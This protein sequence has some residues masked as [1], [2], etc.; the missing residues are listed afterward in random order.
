M[1]AIKQ[2]KKKETLGKK[3]FLADDVG[4]Y[5]KLIYKSGIAPFDELLKNKSQDDIK[6]KTH[7]VKYP[8]GIE[9]KLAK[10]FT[11]YTHAISNE[12]IESLTFQNPNQPVLLIRCAEKK[13]IAFD[14]SM[15][16]LFEIL[17]LLR[18]SYKSRIDFG[19]DNKELDAF[20]KKYDF[21]VEQKDTPFSGRITGG[22]LF[23]LYV[24]VGVFQ[25]ILWLL[26]KDLGFVTAISIILFFFLLLPAY[27]QRLHDIN[28][29]G[30]Y[31]LYLLI[32]V[33]NIG[34]LVY[35]FITEGTKGDNKYGKDPKMKT[36]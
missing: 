3:M 23:L 21:I 26:S 4:I 19:I 9:V 34:Y 32:P 31:A 25:L 35:L 22:N 2:E 16:D 8:K 17:S 12:N 15:D 14:F 33:F 10:L 24:S 18:K 29:S 1:E 11:S 13:V 20:K 6:A 5:D 27:V 7:L 36:R 28:K 30:V